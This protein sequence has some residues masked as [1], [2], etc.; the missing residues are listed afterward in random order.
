VVSSF[1]AVKDVAPSGL[2]EAHLSR[3]RTFLAQTPQGFRYSEILEAHE[4]ASESRQPYV[5]DGE[6]YAAYIGPVH[7]VEGDTRNRKI[8]FVHDL[9]KP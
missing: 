1:E 9:E 7:T 2:V 5:D 6:V 4:K 3:D 8:T